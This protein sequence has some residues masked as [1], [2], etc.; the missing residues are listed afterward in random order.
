M[1]ARCESS[2]TELINFLPASSPALDAEA[3]D[4]AKRV[5][6]IFD[7][8]FVARVFFQSR[9]VYPGNRRMI[10]QEPGYGERVFRVPALPQRKRFQALQKAGK[11]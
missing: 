10:F 11:S 8:Q 7:R 4:G 3:D 1:F 2:F 5:F 9:I 6:K